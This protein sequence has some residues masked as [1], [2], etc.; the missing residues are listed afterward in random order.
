LDIFYEGDLKQFVIG[1]LPNY[2]RHRIEARHS[3]CPQS[4]LTGYELKSIAV[5]PN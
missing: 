5:S 3:C 1:H 4:A 2:D